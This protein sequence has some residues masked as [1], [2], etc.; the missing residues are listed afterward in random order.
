M[1]DCHPSVLESLILFVYLF[2][3]EA[4]FL[5]LVDEYNSTRGIIGKFMYVLHLGKFPLCLLELFKTI[6]ISIGISW[7]VHQSHFVGTP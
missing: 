3:G 2:V 7:Y 5:F 6:L 1:C 4:S